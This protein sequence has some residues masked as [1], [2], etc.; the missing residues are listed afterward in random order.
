CGDTQLTYAELQREVW[1]AQQALRSLGVRPTER[2]AMVVDD[3]PAFIAWFLGALRS[4]V[5]PV[6]LS[7]MLTAG[8]LGPIVDD[9]VAD[10]VVASAQHAAKVE[11]AGARAVVLVDGDDWGCRDDRS[12]AVVG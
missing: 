1:R 5:V 8:E 2:V 7:T 12:E 3:E 9:A 11:A 10:V 6:P 4:G